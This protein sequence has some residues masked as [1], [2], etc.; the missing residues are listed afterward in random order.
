L[1]DG[2]TLLASSSSGVG[3]LLLFPTFGRHNG[4]SSD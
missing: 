4:R 2:F 1:S 3:Q